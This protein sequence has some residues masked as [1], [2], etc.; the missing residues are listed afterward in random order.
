[1]AQLFPFMGYLCRTT[2]PSLRPKHTGS[3]DEITPQYVKLNVKRVKHANV[4]GILAVTEEGKT[5]QKII[6]M[7]VDDLPQPALLILIT[8]ED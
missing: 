1:M 8:S 6:A 2:E 5:D 4:L 3:Y 7:R